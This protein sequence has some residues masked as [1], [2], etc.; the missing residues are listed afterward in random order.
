MKPLQKVGLVAGG[1]IVCF[2][3]AFAAVAVHAAITA[4]S[5][6]QAT[7]GMY[8]FGDTI[9]FIAVFGVSALVPTG[10]ALVFL[11]PYRS[12]WIALS[13]LGA[14]VAVTGIA[15]AILFAVGRNESA[16]RLATLA[17]LSVLRILV[18]PLLALAFLL[19]AVLSPRGTPRRALLTSAG[20]EMAVSAYGAAVWFIPHFLHTP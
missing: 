6:G 17:Q 5:A 3:M 10:A 19:C 4:S 7:G 18:A 16:S 20:V 14:A 12:F 8:A 9:L 15:A 13:A 11:R 1:Y 2:I